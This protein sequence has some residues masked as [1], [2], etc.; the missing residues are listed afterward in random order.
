MR[1]TLSSPAHPQS[2]VSTTTKLLCTGGYST[3]RQLLPWQRGETETDVCSFLSLLSSLFGGGVH[4][5]VTQHNRL[6]SRLFSTQQK[7]S[8]THGV[9][10]WEGKNYSGTFSGSDSSSTGDKNLVFALLQFRR[11]SI[12]AWTLTHSPTHKMPP[13][14]PA[15]RT[16]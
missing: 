5:T 1:C 9:T 4:S 13:S 10:N 6:E 12:E 16:N 2:E 15:Q 8:Q 7:T 11:Q 3:V 14:Y